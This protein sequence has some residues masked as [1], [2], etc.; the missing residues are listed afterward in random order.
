MALPPFRA[1][2][3]D[4]N[5]RVYVFMENELDDASDA[6]GWRYLV[7]LPTGMEE[8]EE[9][10]THIQE[11]INNKQAYTLGS[12]ND[13]LTTLIPTRPTEEINNDMYA[14]LYKVV[15]DKVLNEEE[16]IRLPIPYLFSNPITMYDADEEDYEWLEKRPYITIDEL[17]S[18]IETLENESTDI[19]L[20]LPGNAENRLKHMTPG[21][22]GEVYDLWLHKRTDCNLKGLRSLM[23]RVKTEC[24]KEN[25]TSVNP[26]VCFRKRREK[27]QT[28]RTKKCGEINYFKMLY[29]RQN[30]KIFDRLLKKMEEREKL[31]RRII[32]ENEN[33]FNMRLSF[34]LNS[35]SVIS[36]ENLPEKAIVDCVM[37]TII[38]DIDE[39]FIKVDAKGKKNKDGNRKRSCKWDKFLKGADYRKT[40]GELLFNN[41]YRNLSEINIEDSDSSNEEIDD[42]VMDGFEF[43]RKRGVTY[44]APTS[45]TLRLDSSNCDD[46]PFHGDAYNHRNRFYPFTFSSKINGGTFTRMVRKVLGRCGQTFLEYINVD[47][48]ENLPKKLFAVH[49]EQF[50]VNF[51]L[52]S[53]KN[54]C[55]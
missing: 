23:P 13:Q 28:R 45:N 30:I 36:K 18:I 4:P 47:C 26:Y 43:K 40:G 21:I 38:N 31:K 52:P 7:K 39:Y 9:N 11:A 10:E 15:D 42:E 41:R 1:R 20:C 22:V 3:L 25:H 6:L 27:M 35:Q 29:L 48:N 14:S 49:N 37:K 12:T 53:S 5:K 19:T 33:I 51:D 55:N 54:V 32:D 34:D 24:G 8:D 17:E 46:V 50:Q 2:N 44:H 16:Y